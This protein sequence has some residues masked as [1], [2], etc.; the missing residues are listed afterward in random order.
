[1]TKKKSRQNL[2]ASRTKRA[3]DM[4]QK[5]FFIIFKGFSGAKNCLRLE[6]APLI[7]EAKFS[8]DPKQS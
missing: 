7:L 5:A 1:M 2:N 8:D 6:S 3:F 4:K